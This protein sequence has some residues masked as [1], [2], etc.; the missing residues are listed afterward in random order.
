MFDAMMEQETDIPKEFNLS[1][2]IDD[3]SLPMMKPF[4]F[5]EDVKEFIKLLKKSRTKLY[6]IPIIQITE[7]KFNKLA[8]RKLLK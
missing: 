7:K 8:G 1:D 2:K 5:V 3:E 6:G 4:I